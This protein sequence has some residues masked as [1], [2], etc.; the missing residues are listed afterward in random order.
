MSGRDWLIWVAVILAV[1]I[2]AIVLIAG[3]TFVPSAAVVNL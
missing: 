3:S 2:L 1:M